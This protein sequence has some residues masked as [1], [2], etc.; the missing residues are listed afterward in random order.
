MIIKGKK[1]VK[2]IKDFLKINLPLQ[3]QKS[4]LLIFL[5]KINYQQKY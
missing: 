5:I 4:L 1:N 2:I 3:K